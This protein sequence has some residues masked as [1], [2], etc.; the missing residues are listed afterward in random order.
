MKTTTASSKVPASGVLAFATLSTLAILAIALASTPSPAAEEKSN[1]NKPTLNKLEQEFVDM[2]SHSTL[3]GHWRLASPGEMGEEKVEKYSITTVTKIKGE[4]WLIWARIQ[5]AS[6]DVN[7]PVPVAIKWAG[8]TPILFVTDAGLPGLGTYT[9]RVMF[10]R[11]LYTGTWFASDHGGMLSGTIQKSDKD[12][13]AKASDDAAA[14][15]A[16]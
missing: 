13:P 16:K 2:L 7:I 3:D 10:Y 4:R 11:N 14:P 1:S 12:A 15:S 5:Y 6:K 8:D 9:A